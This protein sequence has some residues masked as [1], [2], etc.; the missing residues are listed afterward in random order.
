[1]TVVLPCLTNF[2]SHRV[3]VGMFLSRASFICQGDVIEKMQITFET[4]FEFFQDIIYLNQDRLSESS[5]VAIRLN[6]IKLSEI[7]V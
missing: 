3:F 7:P 5:V 4:L 1:M 6:S 2:T